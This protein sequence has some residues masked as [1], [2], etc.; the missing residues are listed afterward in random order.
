[1][2]DVGLVSLGYEGRTADELIQTCLAQHVS[3]LVDVRLTPLSRKPGLS[4]TRLAE[5]LAD[6]GIRY[7]HLRALGNPKDNREAFRSGDVQGGRARFK[8]LLQ[9]ATA[10]E[11]L[12]S[13]ACLA[14][15]HKVA[16]LCFE[17]DA[18]QCHRHVV[19]SELRLGHGGEPALTYA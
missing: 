19:T 16:V 15:Q 11:A 3:V 4:K 7:V 14:A 13:L 9:T 5:R 6:A 1:M 12:E 17:R 8:A 2:Q 18:E 10:Q